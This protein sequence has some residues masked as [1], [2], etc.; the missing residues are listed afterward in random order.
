MSRD[1][2]FILQGRTTIA[3]DFPEYLEHQISIGSD[4]VVLQEWIG[5]TWIST[6]FLGSNQ[7]SFGQPLLF[8]TMVEDEKGEVFMRYSTWDEALHGH[9]AIVAI[10]EERKQPPW[11]WFS[12]PFIL[13][14][15]FQAFY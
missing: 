3:V 10:L 2:F 14:L 13:M 6:V 7:A 15:V 1:R 8:E 9:R 5:G 4:R 12:V 11:H